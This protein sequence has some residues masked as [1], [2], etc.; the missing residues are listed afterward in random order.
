MRDDSNRGQEL[1]DILAPPEDCLR[2]QP[3]WSHQSK[4]RSADRHEGNGWID[5]SKTKQNTEIRLESMNVLS[6][7]IV[8]TH[9][10]N[11]EVQN[12][13]LLPRLNAVC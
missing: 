4:Q 10:R 5:M 13:I 11:I 2:A 8:K 7:C 1:V 3:C 12:L 9:V 6:I